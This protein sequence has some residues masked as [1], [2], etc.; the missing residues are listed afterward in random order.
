MSRRGGRKE[1]GW[2]LGGWQRDQGQEQDVKKYVVS[3][4]FLPVP[5]C[6]LPVKCLEFQRLPESGNA[7]PNFYCRGPEKI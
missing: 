1:R 4:L 3:Q 5:V 2:L 7:D 6:S